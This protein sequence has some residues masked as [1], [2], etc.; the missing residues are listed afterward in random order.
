MHE[1]SAL[2]WEEREL[3]DVLLF[4]LEVEQMLLASGNSRWLNRSTQEVDAVQNRLGRVGLARA[5]ELDGVAAEWQ[6]PP[7]C[8]LRELAEHAPEGPWAEILNAHAAGLAQIVTE[9]EAIRSSNEQLIRGALRAT[10][11][12]LADSTASPSTYN[13]RGIT[14]NGRGAARLIDKE[15]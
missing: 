14:D 6:A 8:G 4:K 7:E 5:V 15:M 9:V 13:A 2:L 12:T 11:E 1:A 10:Q 3:L